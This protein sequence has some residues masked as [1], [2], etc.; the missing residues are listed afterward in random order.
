MS[1]PAY[2]EYKYSGV[3]WLG[4]L[5]AHWSTKPLWSMFTRIKKT[6]F[7]D[8]AMLSVYREH[9][10]VLKDSRDDN[11]NK[12]AEDRNI[13]Q[14]VGPGWLVTNRMK[15][16]QG[17]VG[18]SSHRGIVSGHYICFRPVHEEIDSYLNQL[19][20]SSRYVVGYQTLSRGVRPGQAEIDNDLYRS[21]P[22][23]VPPRDE[24][25]AIAEFLDTE[26]AKIDALI[27]KQERLIAT[28]REDRAATINHAVTKGLDPDAAM[29][30]SGIQWIADVPA[31][32]S[33]PQVGMHTLIG[34]GAT[35][36]RENPQY[37]VAGTVPWLNSGHVNRAEINDADQF[38]TELARREC[39]LR[40]VPASSVLVGLTGQGKTR[41]MAS[42]LLTETTI[43]QHLAYLTPDS[44]L[45]ARF[46]HRVMMS[47]YQVLRDLS[48]ENG[49]TK[50][51]LT[52]AALRKVRVPLP[53]SDEQRQ[54]VDFLDER[55]GT[56]DSLI[57]KANDVIE[58][59]GEYRSALI[60]D[61]VTGKI[62]VRA[63]A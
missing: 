43:N 37:W 25:L 29:T 1:W 61:A 13:Y 36:A 4:D 53:P 41:G 11:I 9:G 44:A 63:A 8:E 23:V 55:C 31:H 57:A 58:T 50:G 62:D 14:L 28:L 22:V 56:I 20:R 19:L 54:I 10:V 27:V 34:N 38:V 33:V 59:L 7:P 48:D 39:H 46:L 16:W 49:S 18:I 26:I 3:D 5:P 2:G 15:A 6:G 30:D 32:W 42:I 45:H 51:G 52:C 24:Q 40:L 12:T 21:M 47:A 17:S 60:T 35:P